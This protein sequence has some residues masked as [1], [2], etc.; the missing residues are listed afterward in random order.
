MPSVPRSVT[1]YSFSPQRSVS[2]TSNPHIAPRLP[3]TATSSLSSHP[4]CAAHS[5]IPITLLSITLQAIPLTELHKRYAQRATHT[6]TYSCPPIAL[7]A[8]KFPSNRTAL[9][10]ALQPTVA[11]PNVSTHR[12]I[13]R[14]NETQHHTGET[15][16][17]TAPH[18]TSFRDRAR[19]DL[20]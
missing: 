5:E 13:P 14:K 7:R 15:V 4:D 2:L 12:K 19:S 11:Y 3:Q 17:Y 10:A 20:L 9:H 8:R 16:P 18:T 6:A 1:A